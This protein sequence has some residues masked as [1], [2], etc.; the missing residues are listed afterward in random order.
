MTRFQDHAIFALTL[1]NVAAAH[2]WV[3]QLTNIAPNGSFVAGPG[4]AR[5]FQD[6]VKNFDQEANKWVIP[7]ASAFIDE[8]DL[9]CHPSQRT[10][11]QSPGY[12]RLQTSPGSMVAM[13]YLE[14]GH[15]TM[16]GSGAGLIGK[17]ARGGTV[18]VF[19]TQN[20]Q[21]EETLHSVLAWTRDG[22]GGNKRGVLL[23]AQN[24]DDGRCYQLGNGAPEAAP[25]KLRTPNPIL[26]QSGKEHEL[27]CE[28]DVLLPTK[29]DMSKPYTLYWVWQ[30]P[31][32]PSNDTAPYGKDQYYTSCVDIDVVDRIQSKRGDNPL[33]Q[34]D[35]MANAVHDFRSRGALTQDPLA[36][37]SNP[38]FGDAVTRST[39]IAAHSTTPSSTAPSTA[40]SSAAPSSAAP[41]SAAPSSAAP[42]FAA[43]SSAAPSAAS[44]SSSA[45]A[46]SKNP[47]SGG[48]YSGSKRGLAYND[49]SLCKTLGSNFGFGY[50]WAQVENNDIGTNFIPMM[51]RPSESTPEAWLKNIDKACAKGTK[52]V[53]G[54]NEPD[55]AEQANLSPE[56]ACAAWKQYMNPVASSHPEVTIIGPSVTNGPSPM[57]LSWLEKF[58]AVCPDAI[59]HATNIHFYDIYENAT[60][61]RFR[62]QVEKAAAIYGK[63]VW[64]TE[65]GLNPGSASTEQA[66]KFL[67]EAMAYLDASDKVQGYSWFMVGAGE[68]QLN[69]GTGLSAL[70]QAYAKY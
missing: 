48:N 7:A 53:M 13:R 17:P 3:E 40:P 16:G 20:P 67:T 47:S 63:P 19:G 55:H 64:I 52:A 34:Q 35:Q 43:P 22:S 9:L 66:V 4:Y 70:G 23:T 32:A 51:H 42:S 60:I 56:A 24:F 2:T 28:T 30:W 33:I 36:L 61:T 44:S 46:P 57:G 37:S 29:I 50:N 1:I 68:N 54:F 25:R 11:V 12:P 14:N 69:S 5:A 15:A 8:K 59:V 62:A 26:G 65:F 31:T 49:A 10:A 18:F 6:R 58:H 45:A 41:S 27:P 38:A 39:F 21:K